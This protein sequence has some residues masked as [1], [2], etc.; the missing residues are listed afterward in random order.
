MGAVSQMTDLY[1]A[2]GALFVLHNLCFDYH[3]TTTGL[4]D[5]FTQAAIERIEQAAAG[6]AGD[7]DDEDPLYD[8]VGQERPEEGGG[9]AAEGNDLLRAG[10]VFRNLCVDILVP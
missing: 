9:G 10:E 6:E 1:Q 4:A 8:A 2:I 3:D 7:S 5:G